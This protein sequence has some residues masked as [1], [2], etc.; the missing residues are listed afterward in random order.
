MQDAELRK[1]V[2]GAGDSVMR[3][4]YAGHSGKKASL[5]F[6]AAYVGGDFQRAAINPVAGG[7]ID[8]RH[9]TSVFFSGRYLLFYEERVTGGRHGIGLAESKGGLPSEQY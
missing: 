4:F 6:A 7:K 1:A 9:P 8:L 5:G 3:L 2:T